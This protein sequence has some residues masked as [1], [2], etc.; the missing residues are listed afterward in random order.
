MVTTSCSSM[1]LGSSVFWRSGK[2]SCLRSRS[3]RVAKRD[4]ARCTRLGSTG[5]G[6]SS[7]SEMFPL[8]ATTF[9]AYRPTRG[10]AASAYWSEALPPLA[11][12]TERGFRSALPCP[13]E[14]RSSTLASRS[15]SS[16]SRVT[17]AGR[18]RPAALL[19]TTLRS[20]RSPSRRKRGT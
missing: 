11:T 10:G 3:F 12:V 13:P 15:V 7:P 6:R 8:V 5:I 17:L 1:R 19:S 2:V 4:C 16:T 18:S 9:T 20:A 14:K